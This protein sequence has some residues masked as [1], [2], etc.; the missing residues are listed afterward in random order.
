V[1]ARRVVVTVAHWTT[2]TTIALLVAQTAPFDGWYATAATT[3]IAAGV[4]L[5]GLATTPRKGR[6]Q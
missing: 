1:T 5:V 3:G 4:G 6:T 2:V